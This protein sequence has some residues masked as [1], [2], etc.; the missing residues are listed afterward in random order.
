MRVVHEGARRRF[1]RIIFGFRV[2]GGATSGSGGAALCGVLGV[3][4]ILRDWEE[5]I[6]RG[7]DRASLNHL[8]YGGSER[9][10]G[11]H[12]GFGAGGVA[13]RAGT[14]VRNAERLSG[15]ESFTLID[16]DNVY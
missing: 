16:R 9:K 1:S 15:P 6:N 8:V 3:T 14:K 12:R 10:D 13:R 2:Q 4:C 5:P 11:P 7:S